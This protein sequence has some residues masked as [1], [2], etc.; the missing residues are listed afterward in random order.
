MLPAAAGCQQL[1]QPALFCDVQHFVPGF[2]VP[3]FY[4]ELQLGALAEAT[5]LRERYVGGNEGGNVDVCLNSIAGGTACH[6]ARAIACTY[7]FIA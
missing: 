6:L 2:D 3:D 4:G 1:Q 5:A 7:P